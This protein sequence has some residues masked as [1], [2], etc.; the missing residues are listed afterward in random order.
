MTKQE[1]VSVIRWDFF[2]GDLSSMCEKPNINRST[3][4]LRLRSEEEKQRKKR[5]RYEK[6]M[7]EKLFLWKIYAWSF[8]VR[9]K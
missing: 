8:F 5:I 3:I 7:T 4:Y 9:K 2:A 6:F 1:N